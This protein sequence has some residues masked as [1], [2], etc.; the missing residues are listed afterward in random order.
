MV[1][2]NALFI[3]QQISLLEFSILQPHIYQHGVTANVKKTPE[4]T[5]ILRVLHLFSY[6]LDTSSY[7][8]Q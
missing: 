8:V 5:E 6:V 3:I 7:H 2:L 4:F 1:L